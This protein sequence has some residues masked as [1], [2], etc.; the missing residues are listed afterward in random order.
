MKRH[1]I[2]QKKKDGGYLYATTD[3]AAVYDRV[4]NLGADRLVYVIDAR[5]SLHLK[6][7]FV[8]SKKPELLHQKLKWSI[9]RLEQ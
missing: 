7:L 6:Q 1:F 2:I 4:H 3:I 9:P 8:V 5:Q